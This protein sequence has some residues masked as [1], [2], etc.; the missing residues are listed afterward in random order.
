MPLRSIGRSC[1]RSAAAVLCAAFLCQL[2][3]GAPSALAEAGAPEAPMAPS[4][5]ALDG[6]RFAGPHGVEGDPNPDD[7][8]FTFKDGK[9][10]S[11]SCLEWG[12]TPAPYWVRRDAKGL[13]FLAEL[14]S[15]DHGT[16]RYEGVFDGRELRGTAQWRKERWY[17]TIERTYRFSGRP[18]PAAK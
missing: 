1:L 5:T 17:W 11:A 18:S 8:V 14:V 4:H 13:H 16:L 9:F 2:A 7:D 12:F 3:L 10:S 15:P 6:T